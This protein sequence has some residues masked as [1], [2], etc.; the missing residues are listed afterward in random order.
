MLFSIIAI[1]SAIIAAVGLLF[2]GKL[3]FV[4]FVFC[5]SFIALFL[6]WAISCVL[7]TLFA[8]KNKP[9]KKHSRIFRF[10]ANCII[11]SLMQILRVE[12]YVTGMDILPQEKFLLVGNHRSSMDPIL[13]MGVLRKYN[14]GFIAKQELFNIP[15][16][17][18]I[19]HKC[20]CL[21]LNRG[22]PREDI[23]A[24][25]EAANLIKNQTA[26]IGIYPE[27][28]RNRGKG[29]LPFKNGA[30]KIAQKA[31]CPIVV[32]SIKN[33]EQI[34]KN[35]PFKKTDVHIDFIG[36]IDADFVAGNSTAEISKKAKV[37]LEEHL[38]EQKDV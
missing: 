2:N 11:D 9:C 29:L 18:K 32:A 4:P 38:T 24:I 31:N 14:A 10:Y 25:S 37:M 30:F 1:I 15:V 34:T 6:L 22:N 12:L 5:V 17:G 16:I 13:E 20:F 28:T 35:A 8:S 27:G 26:V 33:S 7:C 23:K 19:M 21:S 3:Y 36:V